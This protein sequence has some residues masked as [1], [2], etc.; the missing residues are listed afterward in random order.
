MIALL[1]VTLGSAVGAPLRY[2][3]DR[4]IQTR[5]ERV[6]PFGTLAINVSGSLAL[7]LLVGAAASGGVSQLAVD[8]IGIGV[9]G[10]YTTFSTFSWETLRMVEE[11]S[12]MQATANIVVS[13]G[14][15][16]AAAALGFGLAT[17]G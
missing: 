2:V 10:A 7:G 16:L 13:V 6:F 8:A 5:H 9:I 4:E 17:L 15:G 11:G 14:G 1:L 3:L 12:F